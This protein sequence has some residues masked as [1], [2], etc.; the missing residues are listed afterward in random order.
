MIRMVNDRERFLGEVIGQI[1]SKEAKVSVEKELNY[2]LKE[3]KEYWLGKGLSA[4]EAQEKAIKQMGDP[5]KLGEKMNKLY[6]PKVDWLL[7]SLLAAVM[8]LG[9]LPI[10]SMDSSQVEIQDSFMRNRVIFGLLGIALAIGIMYFDYRKLQRWGWA[11][12]LVGVAILYGLRLIPSY[13]INGE[14]YFGIPMLGSFNCWIALPFF[15]LAWAQ[16]FQNKKLKVWQLFLL[17]I[18]SFYLFLMVPD[19]AISFIYGMTVLIMLWWSHLSKK[20]ALF[21][22]A[23]TITA[24]IIGLVAVLPSLKGYQNERIAAYINP[25]KYAD[26]SGY[27][28]VQLRELMTEAKWYGSSAGQGNVLPGTYSDYAL[29]GLTSHFGYVVTVAVLIILL[30]FVIRMGYIAIGARNRYGKLLVIGALALFSLQFF[31]NIAMIFGFVPIMTI[32][33]P[34]ISYGWMSTILNA[35]LIGIVLSVYRR[36]HYGVMTEREC[37][38]N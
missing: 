13:T 17:F 7:L 3:A 30:L 2:H 10:L 15:F 20:T 34:F 4:T 27:M 35:F 33:L 14:P 8:M 32:Y 31:Y 11:F 24:F 38:V 37:E 28:Y 12:Y 22:T 6:R 19:L 21:I 5:Y 23:S 18:Y 16:F 1:R 29:A 36:K 9:F 26:G 25:E